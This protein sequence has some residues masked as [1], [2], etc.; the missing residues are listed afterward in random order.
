MPA[1]CALVDPGA[2][3]P[4]GGRRA[5]PGTRL[6]HA[7]LRK[8]VLDKVL[9]SLDHACDAGFD[10]ANGALKLNAVIARGRN[11]HQLLPLAELARQRGI[12]LRLIEF[13]DVGNRNGWQ[14]DLVLP[15]AE[16]VRRIGARWPL[17]P[18]GRQA[19]GTASRWRASRSCG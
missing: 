8:I 3:T 18:L 2:A 17:V 5:G 11:E 10:P 9:A 4:A 12:E 14:P 13:M 1:R 6:T 7:V 15:A 16:M 19:H